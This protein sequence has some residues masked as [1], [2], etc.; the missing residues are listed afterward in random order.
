MEYERRSPRGLFIDFG[1]DD[2]RAEVNS[3]PAD[4]GKEWQREHEAEQQ[5][6][7]AGVDDRQSLPESKLGLFL[8]HF[9][10]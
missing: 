2:R 4:D 10:T 3:P 9:A 8:R 6:E 7:E 1:A 5:E